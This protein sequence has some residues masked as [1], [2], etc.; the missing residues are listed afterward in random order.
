MEDHAALYNFITREISLFNGVTKVETLIR[1]E[2]KKRTYV[3]VNEHQ[4]LN[5]INTERD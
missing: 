1:A 3:F 4:L 2:L 5:G